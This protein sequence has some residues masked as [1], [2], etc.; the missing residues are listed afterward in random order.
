MIE[1]SVQ[2]QQQHQQQ[3][4]QRLL[5][6]KKRRRQSSVSRPISML[7][8]PRSLSSSFMMVL[9]FLAVS[10]LSSSTSVVVQAEDDTSYDYSDL[11]GQLKMIRHC[12][13]NIVYVNSLYLTCDSPGS[14]YYGSGGYRKSSRCKYGDKADMYIFCKFMFVLLMC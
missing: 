5:L 11:S 6:K 13:V 2:Q 3:K 10:L 8:L 12:D 14:Y 4:E 7:L 9:L 1:R